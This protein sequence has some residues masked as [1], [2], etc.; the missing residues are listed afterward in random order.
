M[1]TRKANGE[2]WISSAPNAQGYY[3]AKVWMGLK[4]NG[5]P[6]RRNVRRRSLP[7]LKKRVREL[8]QA[9]DAGRAP[10]AGR[11]PKVREMLERHLKTVLP[12]AGRSPTTIQSYRSLCKGHI[13][14]QW[15]EQ[16][17]DRL[18][19]E[20]VEDGI[21]EMLRAGLAPATVRKVF[22][23]LSS[24]YEVQ[25]GRKNLT[26][27]PC[28]FVT[29][30]GPPRGEQATLTERDVLTVLTAAAGRPNGPRWGLGLGLGLRQ[31]EALGLRWEYLN[32]ETGEMRVWWQLQRI[33]WA[34]GCADG[35]PGLA[36]MTGSGAE[37]AREARAG[38]LEHA[39]AA[40]HCKKKPCPRKCSRHE[41][42]CPPPC[43]D[44]CTGHARLC[45]RRKGGGLVLR[46]VKEKRHKTIWLAPPWLEYLRKHRDAQFL[47]KIT[48]DAEWEDH[49][50][51]F[52]Q[53]NGRPVDPRRDWAEWRV[54]LGAAGLPPH[55]VH[56]MRHTAA[57]GALDEGVALAVVKDLLGHS[58]IRVT[59]IYTHA[60][61]A[62]S[63]D[64]SGRMARRLGLSVSEPS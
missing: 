23:V 44:D 1:S 25:V 41:R 2:S 60:G 4:G 19:P 16:R 50:L 55:R 56:A 28:E 12:A 5:K 6:D 26:R 54:I 51:V 10:K 18:L 15:G 13:Y 45:P 40:P 27:N 61:K 48:V 35:D 17:A 20:D 49:D 32:L 53:W 36:A 39:C 64:A 24:A 59:E 30:P 29:P 43:P 7:E 52:C 21:A 9:R 37:K 47:Q 11:P 8:E 31:G 3:E 34:H 14:P 33:T 62:H 63:L 57:T 46:P 58:D 42:R 22:A 38:M